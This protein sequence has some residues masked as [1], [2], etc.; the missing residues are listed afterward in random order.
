MPPKL[1]T[2]KIVDKIIKRFLAV[3]EEF[4]LLIVHIITRFP[5][6]SLRKLIYAIIGIEIG[7]GSVIH[8]GATLYTLGNI[9]IGLD[10]IVGEKTTLDGRGKLTI[11]N[12]VAIASE[13]MIY[14]SKHDINSANFRP[15]NMPVII[16]DYVFIGPRAIILPGVVIEK[17]AVVGAGAVITKN[18][19]AFGI[20]GGVP[21]RQINTRQIKNPN[22][23]LGRAR[24]FR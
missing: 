24:L 11:G 15:I 20:V 22:Y 23:R 5:S 12:H 10:T 13:V 14:T 3:T 8:C 2:T 6:H 18:V 4:L 7:K 16:E 17:G 21:A 1:S 19:P 9:K